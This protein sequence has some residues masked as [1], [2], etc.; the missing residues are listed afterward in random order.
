MVGNHGSQML[1]DHIL[2]LKHKADGKVEVGWH[3]DLSESATNDTLPSAWLQ[4]LP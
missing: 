2:H 4:H 1:S 3:Y